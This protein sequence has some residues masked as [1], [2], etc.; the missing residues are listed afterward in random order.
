MHNA[1][2][3]MSDSNTPIHHP[4]IFCQVG[5]DASLLPEEICNWISQ[6][7]T[8]YIVLKSKLLQFD[9]PFVYGADES[10][11]YVLTPLLL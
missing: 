8:F 2:E 3:T 11:Y 1:V 5:L 7:I 4:S 9:E 10:F 6:G